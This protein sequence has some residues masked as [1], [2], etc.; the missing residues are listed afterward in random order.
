MRLP[1]LMNYTLAIIIDQQGKDVIYLE[2]ELRTSA[3][4]Y[5]TYPDTRYA[6]GTKGELGF[7]NT[8][9]VRTLTTTSKKMRV[10]DKLTPAR[11]YLNYNYWAIAHNGA[12]FQMHQ[13]I[14]QQGGQLQRDQGDTTQEWLTCAELSWYY[15]TTGLFCSSRE[16]ITLYCNRPGGDSSVKVPVA[17][18]AYN[19]TGATITPKLRFVTYTYQVHVTTASQAKHPIRRIMIPPMGDVSGLD[20]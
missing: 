15:D 17:F 11:G 14:S 20:Q 5:K 16:F 9:A 4:I 6:V 18:E 3:P 7:G 19:D 1:P 8:D 13:P 12:K 10:I 2:T